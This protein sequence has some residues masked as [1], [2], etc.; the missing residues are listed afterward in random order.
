MRTLRIRPVVAGLLALGASPA[1]GATVEVHPVYYKPVHESDQI[2]YLAEPGERNLPVIT[3]DGDSY[4]I[5]D[6][7]DLV[8]GAGCVAEAGGA[9]RCTPTPNLSSFVRVRL[10]DRDDRVRIAGPA[11]S[12]LYGGPGND[13]L[14]GAP[15]G[16][17]TFDGGPGNDRMLGGHS[18]DGFLEGRAPNGADTM[19][20]L[21]NG[22]AVNGSAVIDTVD[23]RLRRNAVHVTLDAVRDDGEVGER[24]LIGPNVHGVEG[25]Y[26][27]DVLVGGPGDDYL[28][29]HDRRDVL[30]G[31]GGNDTLQGDSLVV[32]LKDTADRLYGG[33]GDDI[34]Q[35]GSGPDFFLGG[36]GEDSVMAGPGNDGVDS[37]DGQMDF[38]GC[39]D[40]RDW[41]D[42]DNRDLLNPDCE[43]TRRLEP[44]GNAGRAHALLGLAHGVLAVVEDR[45]A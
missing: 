1:A 32:N 13:R 14:V 43:S 26:W 37:N 28:D 45:R 31:K 21:A 16:P 35:G 38:V 8:P 18:W 25:G 5:T 6:E 15:D 19:A 11:W 34:M 30:K 29:G 27:A 42:K 17:T 20:S 23:Y 3:R 41:V 4:L 10:G 2:R 36:S 33:P 40:G 22:V 7:V 9:V 12:V 39:G 44:D 24:D